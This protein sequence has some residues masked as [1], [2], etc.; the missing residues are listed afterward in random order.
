MTRREHLAS[1]DQ[2]IKDLP[3]P[4]AYTFIKNLETAATNTAMKKATA[5]IPTTT[6]TQPTRNEVE[7]SENSRLTEERD[8]A[9]AAQIL[10]AI[11]DAE[12]E[13]GLVD[14]F[15]RRRG[16]PQNTNEGDSYCQNIINGKICGHYMYHDETY[17]NHCQYDNFTEDA[18]DL[19]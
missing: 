16:C 7:M 17:C 3:P 2:A 9:L 18:L 11:V 1:L 13:P 14:L 8:D 5:A 4:L 19:F 12:A 6:T 10:D 15:D